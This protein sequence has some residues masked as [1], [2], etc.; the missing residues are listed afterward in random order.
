MFVG[1]P[2][3]RDFSLYELRRR[4]FLGRIKEQYPQDKQ[5]LIVLFAGLENNQQV[6]R[7]E[8]SFYYMTG[9]QE[10]GLVLTID[11]EG[12]S[13]IYAPNFGS[14]R[15]VWVHSEVSVSP[16]N[17]KI[18]AV[19]AV[20]ELGERCK[21]YQFYPFFAQSEY[22]NLLK[23]LSDATSQGSKLYTLYPS[24][25]YEY[26]EQRNILARIE[27]FMPSISEQ[28][29]DVSPIIAAM[30]R[31]KDAREIEFL[32]EAV[33]ITQLAHEAA[34]NM[35]SK[36][37][38]EAEVQGALEYIMISS[39]GRPSFP[40][41]VAGGKNGTILHYNSNNHLLND[42]D[43]AVIDI[44]TQ[45]AGYC[46]DL[47]R[48]YPVSGKFSVRQKELYTIVLETQEYIASLAQP[49]YWLSYDKEPDRS[50]NHLA[51]KF[52][53]DRG[54]GDYCP[55]GIGHFLGLDVHDVGDYS[56]PLQEGDVITIEPGIYI[57]QEATG[58]RIEDNYWI[59]KNGAICLSDGLGKTVS[60]IEMLMQESKD[61]QENAAFNEM[62]EDKEY[63]EGH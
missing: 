32:Y 26:V 1:V 44:G 41:I 60:E 19:Q 59:V 22:K 54:Y 47:T 12:N 39:G 10:P 37:V 16:E 49:G 18:L 25:A 63:N 52:L 2:E 36:D 17:T 15:A 24:N 13:T 51:R 27:K 43:L 40:S 35:I 20:E 56:R 38:N 30:R 4:D 3:M 62:A 31:I 14:N 58:I 11:F 53:Q 42:G 5:G 33:G 23:V 55:H 61:K 9:L 57:P 8:S 7:Q 45:F 48:T 28:L 21:G 34:A 50:L 46:A 29:V 6:F